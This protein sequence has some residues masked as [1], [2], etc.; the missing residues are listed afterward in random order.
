[1]RSTSEFSDLDLVPWFEP[2]DPSWFT[3]YALTTAGLQ[4]IDT[5]GPQIFDAGVRRPNTLGTYQGTR[6]FWTSPSRIVTYDTSNSEDAL[7]DVAM[8]A[9]GATTTRTVTSGLGSFSVSLVLVGGRLYDRS[10]AVL[11]ANALTRVGAFNL[12]ASSGAPSAFAPA[13]DAAASRAYFVQVE[14]GVARLLTYDAGSFR[15]LANRRIANLPNVSLVGPDNAR[16]RLVGEVL[17]IRLDDRV[18]FVDGVSRL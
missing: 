3:T 8:D 4:S 6:L 10:G 14:D 17:T 7:R 15:L 2:S 13:V 1:M 9:N 12:P 11:D 5:D 16:V 18:A